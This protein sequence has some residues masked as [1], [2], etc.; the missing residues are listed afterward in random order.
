MLPDSGMLLA[1]VQGVF[2][3]KLV[4]F[5]GIPFVNG[6]RDFTG[7][8]CWGLVCL[9]YRH[10]FGT[11]LE[12]YQISCFD[13]L[14]IKGQ[15]EKEVKSAEI[16]KEINIPEIPC[17]V[18]MSTNPNFPRFC[19]HLGLY[20]EDQKFLH[21]FKKK[22]SVLERFDHPFFKRKIQMYLKYIG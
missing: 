22:D 7:C 10:L 15:I 3:Y 4:D 5:I 6:G 21:T 9:A 1:L 8:D 2:M 19:N 16:W 11:E 17:L 13:T 20:V 14:R 18:V 12:D